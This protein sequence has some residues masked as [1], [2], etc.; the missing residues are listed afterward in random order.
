MTLNPKNEKAAQVAC[1]SVGGS[2]SGGRPRRPPPWAMAG[3]CVL[4]LVFVAAV[5][6]AAA[7]AAAAAAGVVV[8]VVVERGLGFKA[9]CLGFRV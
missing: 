7:A 8:V 3:R 9:R 4:C 2:P 6:V 1:P 5:V